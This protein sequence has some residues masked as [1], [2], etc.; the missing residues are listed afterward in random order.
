M[1]G[2]VPGLPPSNLD[3]NII[4]AVAQG[5]GSLSAVWGSRFA[6]CFEIC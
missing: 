5:W 1:W 6:E 4:P 2:F 3:G